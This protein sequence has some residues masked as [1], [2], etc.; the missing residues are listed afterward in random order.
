MAITLLA[1]SRTRLLPPGKAS[2]RA[3]LSGPLGRD[4]DCARRRLVQ[5]ISALFCHLFVLKSKAWKDQ[6]SLL[7]SPLQEYS[8]N[9]IGILRAVSPRFPVC[10]RPVEA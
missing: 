6:K 2:A 9:K 3:A 10:L 4:A 8:D 7:E 5:R 1:R